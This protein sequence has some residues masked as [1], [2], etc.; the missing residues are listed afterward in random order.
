MD[1][2][3]FISAIIIVSAK[4]SVKTESV[5]PANIIPVSIIAIQPTAASPTSAYPQD[6]KT[7][8]ILFICFVY[9]I[10]IV[11]NIYCLLYNINIKGTKSIPNNDLPMSYF[12][13]YY[14]IAII[15][16]LC[17]D[18]NTSK[19]IKAKHLTGETWRVCFIMF[20]K[21]FY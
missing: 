10:Y 11:D 16:P 15:V 21:V 4:K 6:I 20:A 14:K 12:I 9:V 1:H 19:A 17:Y 7:C 13:V 18:V 3:I 8:F 5:G 2:L